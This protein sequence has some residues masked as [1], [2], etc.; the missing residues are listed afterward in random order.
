MKHLRFLKLSALALALLMATAAFG[1]AP[2]AQE[3]PADEPALTGAPETTQAPINTDAPAQDAVPAVPDFS[4]TD[5]DGNS[6]TN[7]VFADAGITF[8]NIWGTFC[9]PCI[10]EMPD[11]GELAEVYADKGVQFIGVIVDASAET[12]EE[13]ELA[14][15]ISEQTGA[16]YL[17]ILNS[18]SVSD[19]MLQEV[20]GVPTTFF[21]NSEGQVIGETYVGSR[22]YEKWAAI[23][24]ELIAAQG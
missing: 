10:N 3:E 17:H 6:V 15:E 8:V 7:A 16:D 20:S 13:I 18:Q 2:S 9:G 4:S 5:L 11:L 24:D 12:A 23:I 14:K 1:C 22:S 19:A 21:V